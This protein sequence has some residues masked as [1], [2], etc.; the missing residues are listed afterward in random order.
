VRF[1]G[2]DAAAVSWGLD[3]SDKHMETNNAERTK[4]HNQINDKRHRRTEV[5]T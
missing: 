1:C 2:I 4:N 5:L 3:G